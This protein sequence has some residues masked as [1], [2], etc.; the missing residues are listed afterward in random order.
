METLNLFITNTFYDRYFVCIHKNKNQVNC[1][2]YK[3][4]EESLKKLRTFTQRENSPIFNVSSHLAVS[5]FKISCFYPIFLDSYILRTKILNV[6]K[7]D[8]ENTRK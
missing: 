6:I 7:L 1:L 3:N 4:E 5:Y 8:I 2:L